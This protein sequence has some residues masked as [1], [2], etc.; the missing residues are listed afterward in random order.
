MADAGSGTA[1][2]R[3]VIEIGGSPVSAVVAAALRQTVVDTDTGGPDMCRLVFDDP[4]RN[5]LSGPG[6]ELAAELTVGAG[7]VGDAEM[8]N[9]FTGRIYALGF[10]HDDRGTFTT[11]TA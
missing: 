6:F 9:V 1:A 3:P 5:L 10:E 2:S 4:G 8:E 7:R 11:V